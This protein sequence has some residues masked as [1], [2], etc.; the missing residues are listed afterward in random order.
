MTA[1]M[2]HTRCC[3]H[4]D[5]SLSTSVAAVSPICKSEPLSLSVSCTKLMGRCQKCF[6]C[7]FFC[8][9]S[10][11]RTQCARV[12]VIGHKEHDGT[13]VHL[14]HCVETVRALSGTVSVAVALS[15]RL[16]FC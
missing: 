9:L 2:T 4:N 13:W 1:K 6:V 14:L 8:C 7:F 10:T 15:M 11:T 5:L 12:A 16:T 3:L